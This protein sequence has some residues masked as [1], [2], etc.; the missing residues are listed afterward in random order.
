MK[1]HIHNARDLI[2]PFIDFFY[3]PFQKILGLGQQTFRYAAAGGMNTLLGLTVYYISYTFILQKQNLDLGFYAFTPHS[4]ALFMSFCISFPV[5]FFL[6]KYVV[7]ENSN[8]N[9]KVQAIRYLLIYLFTLFINY[10]LLKL[11][12]EIG[13]MDAMVAQLISTGVVIT[14]S[15]FGQKYF[16]FKMVNNERDTTG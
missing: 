3:P 9:S 8:I 5:G 11:M 14:V 10:A 7:F 4:A 12:V 15:Y 13:R 2:L 16:S 6:M 1:R